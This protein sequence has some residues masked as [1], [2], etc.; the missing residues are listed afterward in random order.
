MKLHK[1]KYLKTEP[2]DIIQKISV[3]VDLATPGGNSK[4]GLI[5][6]YCPGGVGYLAG[7]IAVCLQRLM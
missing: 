6:Q 1:F 5:L 4:Y 3:L 7:E 2:K